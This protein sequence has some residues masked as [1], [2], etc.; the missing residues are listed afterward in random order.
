MNQLKVD[1]ES[2]IHPDY[3][4][5]FRS[6]EDAVKRLI[7]YH[8]IYSENEPDNE[9]QSDDEEQF[10]HAAHDLS[11]KYKLMMNKYQMLL[12]KESMVSIVDCKPFRN[13]IVSFSFMS[14]D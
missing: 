2:C 9:N 14:V 13:I 3:Q 5:P 8:C 4:N 1:Q 11:D 12:M 10:V 6:K 7:R